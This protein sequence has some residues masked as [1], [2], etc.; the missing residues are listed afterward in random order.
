MVEME[1]IV[2][3]LEQTLGTSLGLKTLNEQESL[4]LTE[5]MAITSR[6]GDRFGREESATR[7]NRRGES[8]S[9]NA[10]VM[11]D[12]AYVHKE[13]GEIW[14]PVNQQDPSRVLVAD[15]N[16]LTESEI[17]LVALYWRAFRKRLQARCQRMQLKSKKNGAPNSWAVG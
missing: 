3:K 9:S 8:V 6:F 11:V 17:G 14:F 1:H 7:T 10:T 16:A 4:W 5:S 2:Q 12:G 13:L 15:S